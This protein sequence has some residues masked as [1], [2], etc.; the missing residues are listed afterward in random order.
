MKTSNLSLLLVLSIFIIL[1]GCSQSPGPL[2][3][4]Y[5]RIEIK[6]SGLGGADIDAVIPG[7]S[8]TTAAHTEYR[9]E[10]GCFFT[11]KAYIDVPVPPY[12]YNLRVQIDSDTGPQMR[13]FDTVTFSGSGQQVTIRYDVGLT[14]GKFKIYSF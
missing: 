10:L 4:G 6:C 7:T 11:G 14:L 13:T 5:S 1:S 8:G 3:D 12:T 9:T 2:A